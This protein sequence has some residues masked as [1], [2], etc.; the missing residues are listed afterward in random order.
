MA[1][2]SD[3][4]VY[5]MDASAFIHRAYHAI[6]NLTTFDGRPTGAA[7]GFTA[8]L[9][10]LLKDKKP[11]YL[12]VVYDSRGP[13]HRHKLYPEYKAKRKPMEPDLIA[14]QTSIRDIVRAMGLFTIEKPEFE[15]D[16]LIASLCGLATSQGH[17]VVIV[18][19]D[20]DFYQLLSADVSMYDPDPKK[21]SAMTEAVFRT[22]FGI[23][24]AAFI[25]MQALMGDPTDN[26]IGVPKV[27]EKTAQKLISEFGTIDNLYQNLSTLTNVKLKDRLAEY[28][29]S[30][31]LSRRLA[32]LGEALVPP[33]TIG[34][35]VRS[36]PDFAALNRLF[37]DLQFG[38]FLKDLGPNLFPGFSEPAAAKTAP[39][40]AATGEEHQDSPNRAQ[41][42]ASRPQTLST[43][44]TP[45][46]LFPAKPP[47]GTEAV[48]SSLDQLI[49]S[50]DA[51]LDAVSE[52][53]NYD[54]YVLVDGQE[55]WQRLLNALD[56]LGS[57]PL[58]VDLETN[59]IHPSQAAIVGMSLA[60][61]E[62]EAFY[63]PVTH[64]TS[65][66]VNQPWEKIV[67]S[68][69]PYLTGPLPP[70]VGQHAKFDW[71]I[72]SRHGLKLPVPADD[73][74]LAS[75]LLNPDDRH[76]LDALSMRFLTH[77]AIA[78]REVVPD[79]KKDFSFVQPDLACRYSAED[80][81]LT[82]RL[83]PL[84]RSQLN[85]VPAL[86]RLYDRVEL[87]LEEL[88]GRME[89]TGVLIDCSV[90]NALSEELSS[91]LEKKVAKIHSLAGRV[92]NPA[93]PKQ[94][95]EILFVELGLESKKK[96]AK[97]TSFSTDNEVLTELATLYPIAQEILDW[98]EMFK[99][100]TTYADKLPLAVNPATGRIH[101]SY[102][103]ALTATG[104]LSS[105]DPNL[106]NIP[107]RTEEGRRIRAA[108]IA[109]AGSKLVSADYSQI[110]LRVMAHFSGDQALIN[111]FLNDEDIHSQTASLM[112]SLP[113]DQITSDKRREAKTINF[114]IIYG[115]GAF[116]LAK[117][118]DISQTQ[119]KN[120]IS[121][122]FKRFPGVRA[123]I[124]NTK[125]AAEKT[126][127]VSTL[128]GRRRYLPSIN[129]LGPAKR[130]A[131]RM[132][133][134]TPIQGTA[135]DIIKMAMLAVDRELTRLKLKSKI[136]LQVHDELILEVPD[137]E[138]TEVKSLVAK[139]MTE[140]ANDFLD[141]KTGPLKVPL[142][143][144]V[145]SANAWVHA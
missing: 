107:A 15:A 2:Q 91:A 131:E 114:G 76:G 44:F 19:G 105:S 28:E 51:G 101:T 8:T 17:Q 27:G 68:I 30:A 97:K 52:T 70:K 90:L 5:L 125:A 46:R 139:Q 93:S 29:Q 3:N 61:G 75:Y 32:L 127:Q 64:Q 38:R 85:K 111:A 116:G 36:A 73:P 140:A 138:L 77:K 128:F 100:K 135:A 37:K 84:L 25:D 49:T 119:A 69:G 45:G 24:P 113:L 133:I 129:S 122:Y 9:I 98:R 6:K 143:V 103:Q 123:F 95:A 78:F 124:E 108:F 118:L 134:N 12:A 63:I 11:T 13:T 59:S 92:F 60:T 141:E 145:A 54:R 58:A 18:S 22:R 16:D 26:I 23:E 65:S 48:E 89:E 39:P 110:E 43:D 137:E 14:Q 42:T 99:L 102:N 35:L 47:I 126:G 86:E 120:F 87:P 41:G 112:F 115:Q 40:K 117:R 4:I 121:S 109:P 62:N 20:K 142:K 136:I 88:L 72:L 31:R 10:K 132:A 80:A 56:K 130:E 67:T 50:S 34:D 104:R 94:L 57:G 81:D 82:R 66:E 33:A 74:M 79:P 106:Q 21:S 71:H 144:D 55:G 53:V 96:T 7:Y 83:G 1:Q